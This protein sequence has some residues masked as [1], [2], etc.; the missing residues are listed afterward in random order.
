MTERSEHDASLESL[1]ALADGE[2]DAAATAR[3]CGHWRDDASVRQRWHAYQMIGDV[4]RSDDLASAA[5][6]DHALLAAVRARLAVE[7]VVLAPQEAPAVAGRVPGADVPAREGHAVSGRRWPWVA[8]AAMAAGFV[9]VVGVVLL[10]RPPALQGGATLAQ[11]LPPGAAPSAPMV[12]A[13]SLPAAAADTTVE[14]QA[15]V[16]SGTLIRDARLDQYLAAHKQFGGSSALGLPSGFL[17]SATS[18][19]P[20]R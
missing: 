20:S 16:A 8:S 13:V 5:R 19:V 14:P 15:L 10:T 4:L 17:R 6:H 12:Q 2:L 1:S 3:A 18:E 9:A 7:P 11:V